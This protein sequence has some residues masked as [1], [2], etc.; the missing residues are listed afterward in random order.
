MK[1]YYFY[2]IKSNKVYLILYTSF[3]ASK[4]RFE[5][6]NDRRYKTQEIILK[7]CPY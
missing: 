6:M 3:C 1:L 4:N 5:R 2:N 7:G